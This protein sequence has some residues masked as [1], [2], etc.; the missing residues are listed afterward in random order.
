MTKKSDYKMDRRQFV[1]GLAAVVGGVVTAA[2]GLPLVGYIVS[3]ALKKSEDLEW[4][5]VGSVSELEPG[6]PTL[7]TYSQIKQ[8]GW[9]RKKIN[10]G[11]YAIRSGDEQVTVLSDICTHLNCK[12]HWDAERNLFVCPCHDGLFSE[13]GAVVS[14]PPPRPLDRL[15]SKVEDD[16]LMIKAEV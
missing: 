15:E 8:V 3:P 1:G 10:Y 7:L 14:G 9:K 16:Q 13:D 6:V 4:I 5:Q 12:V 2:I 11:V